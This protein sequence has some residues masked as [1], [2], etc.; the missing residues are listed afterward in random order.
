MDNRYFHLEKSNHTSEGKRQVKTCYNCTVIKPMTLI[1]LLITK[2]KMIPKHLRIPATRNKGDIALLKQI[3]DNK[4]SSYLLYSRLSRDIPRNFL[5]L[6]DVPPRL[7][8]LEF[9]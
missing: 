1:H 3:K 2:V 8:L 6:S 5:G 9:S 7:S 4:P